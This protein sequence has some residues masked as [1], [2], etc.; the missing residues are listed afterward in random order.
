MFWRLTILAA[1]VA[2]AGT[3]GLAGERAAR[4]QTGQPPRPMAMDPARHFIEEMIP[5]HEDAIVM[6]ELAFAQA[7]HDELRDLATTIIHVQQAE[8][9]Q[10]RAWYRVWYGTDVPPGHMAGMGSMMMG[11]MAGHDPQSI[12]GADPFDRAFID[13]MIPHHQQAVMMASMVLARTDRPELKTLLRAIIDG[14]SAEIEQMRGWY[15]AWYGVP[16]PTAAGGHGQP[17]AAAGA[18]HRVPAPGWGAGPMMGRAAAGGDRAGWCP[19]MH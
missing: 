12:D 2:L 11:G 9:D 8:I 7:N 10:M 14:Q 18:G 6:A 13:A 1:A 19:M 17:G 5:H 3:L 16:T 4:A 15:Q